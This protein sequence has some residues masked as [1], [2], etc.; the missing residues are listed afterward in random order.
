M[1]V[2]DQDLVVDV[3]IGDNKWLIVDGKINRSRYNETDTVQ[4]IA[5]PSRDNPDAEPIEEQEI[6]VKL[7]PR[8]SV[9]T[10][11][12]RDMVNG[13]ELLV[14][15]FTGYVT[16]VFDFGDGSWEIEAVN[17][18]L[19][20]KTTNVYISTDE[21]VRISKLVEEVIEDVRISGGV[22]I[23]YNIDLRPSFQM[24]PSPFGFSRFGS[25]GIV[26]DNTDVLTSKEYTRVK[27][28]EVLDRL[29]EMANAAWWIDVNNRLQFGPTDT[30]GHKLSWVTETSAGK[31]TPPYKSVKVIGDNIVSQTG[32][33]RSQMLSESTGLSQ[34]QLQRF[35]VEDEEIGTGGLVPPTFVY[36]S[37]AIKTRKEAQNVRDRV[38][39]E[40][41]QQ[42]AGG[43]VTV[44]GRPMI[45][46]LD[47]IEMPDSFAR[48]SNSPLEESTTL[49]PAQYKVQAVEHRI[50]GSDGF[51]TK[52]ECGGLADR[53]KGPVYEYQDG[54]IILSTE[55]PDDD[56]ETQ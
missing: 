27:A 11:G 7:G 44:V 42:Q 36:K 19:D 52:I 22:D 55:D 4:C 56:E 43:H 37:E 9:S 41:Q 12:N 31:Q 53:Y 40:L 21:P 2:Y 46:I 38:L 29:S 39:D 30:A 35:G 45:D 54:S 49:E 6:V 51:I 15:V 48:T 33:E 18:M 8:S 32:W 10:D 23:E 17:Y 47:V 28:A 3:T 13:D 1:P 34:G 20:L 26:R 50:N 14:T 25:F 24:P 16:N 5:V